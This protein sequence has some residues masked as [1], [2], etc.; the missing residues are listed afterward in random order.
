MSISDCGGQPQFHDVSPFFI[1]HISVALIVLR[2]TDSFS[3]FPLDE[4]FKDGELMGLPCA[5]HM[6]LGETL[7]N[8]IRSIES[9]SSQEKKPN[10]MFVGTFLDQIVDTKTVDEK[11]KEILDIMS[12]DMKKQVKY[13][14]S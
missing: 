13:N 3:S 11:N 9:H 14:G 8:L 4:Y 2:L 1:R 7:K 10:L 6:T 5:S 12:V